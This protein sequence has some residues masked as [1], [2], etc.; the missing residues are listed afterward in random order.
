[1]LLI[2]RPPSQSVGVD[3]TADPVQVRGHAR[4]DA[5]VVRVP[6]AGAKGHD[7]GHE[8]PLQVVTCHTPHER[9]SAVALEHGTERHIRCLTENGTSHTLFD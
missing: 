2:H 9:P 4:V 8:P 7:A 6:A 3:C 5:G 1:M